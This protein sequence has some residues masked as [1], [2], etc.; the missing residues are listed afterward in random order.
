[1]SVTPF[2][3]SQGRMSLA[4]RS[5]RE[6]VTSPHCIRLSSSKSSPYCLNLM[7]RVQQMLMQ[8]GNETKT[9]KVPSRNTLCTVFEKAKIHF[10]RIQ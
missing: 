2:C 7:T 8:I 4:T 3:M 1:M 5:Q 10:R 9:I 6:V